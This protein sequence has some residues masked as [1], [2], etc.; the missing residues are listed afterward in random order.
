MQ[1]ASYKKESM[2]LVLLRFPC[3][4]RLEYLHRSPAKKREPSA[5][6]YNWATLYLGDINTGTGLSRLGES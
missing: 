1:S 5:R 2:R 4:G 3:G 6:G